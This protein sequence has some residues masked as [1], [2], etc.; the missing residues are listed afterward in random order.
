MKQDNTG[1]N[2]AH[3]FSVLQHLAKYPVLDGR[4]L[5][6]LREGCCVVSH[7]LHALVV[8]EGF[9]LDKELG[10]AVTA[11]HQAVAECNARLLQLNAGV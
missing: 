3:G 11:L 1:Y 10:G 8:P 6:I 5:G 2:P 9:D 4:T 7:K